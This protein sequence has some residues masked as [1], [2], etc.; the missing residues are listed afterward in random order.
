MTAQ[1]LSSNS[2][3][4]PLQFTD[5]AS[6]KRWIGQ[7]PLTNV[8]HAQKALAAQ[9]Q[10]LADMPIPAH[11]RLKILELLKQPITFIQAESAKR[12]ASKPVPLAPAET[13]A[14]NHV[15]ALWQQLS[16]NYEQCLR[17]YRDGDLAIAP[18][19]ALVTMRCLR[20]IAYMMFDYYRTYTQ[21]P[22]TLWRE[23]HELYSF[24]EQHGFARIRIQDSFSR[25]DPDSSC[26]EVYILALLAHVA[27]PYSLSARQLSFVERWLEKWSSLVGLSSQAPLPG[28][29]SL[30][31]VDLAQPE[32]VVLAQEVEPQPSVRYLDLEQLSKTLRQTI[33]LLKQGQLPIHLG[34]G[35][36]ARQPGCEN[37]LMLLYVHWCRA[38]AS[39]SEERQIAE[40]PVEACFGIAAAHRH[41][42]GRE[43]RQ[44]G[45]LS[46]R[47]KQDMDTYGF[48]VRTNHGQPG[49]LEG[50]LES[51]QILNHSASGY[52]C[53]L[54]QPDAA[55]RIEHNQLI[56]VR[57]S[58]SRNFHIGIIQWLRMDD[59]KDLRCGIRLFPGIPRAI[60]VRPSN[61]SPAAPNTYECALLLPEIPV[62]ATPATLILPPSWFQNGRFIEMH[63]DRKQ[64]AKLL[65]LLEKGSDF[66]RGS[67]AVI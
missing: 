22:G 53:I 32:A 50:A 66:D 10:A 48:V 5:S 57:R 8:Q 27:N 17:A 33:N 41:I 30:L 2:S 9:L 12:Y 39:R 14:W 23:L 25:R 24:A 31:A 55:G 56:A 29:I 4:P 51:W 38:G 67:V 60:A 34:L 11:E 3:P 61:P 40:E 42:G 54:R 36:D 7:L 18:H 6:C 44:P 58:G 49:G 52:M 19:A 13:L 35:E 1:P 59:R 16:R 64:I 20:L 43:F 28:P 15:M 65:N 46:S 63:S 26:A 45:Q 47:E 21:T 37:L 62:P